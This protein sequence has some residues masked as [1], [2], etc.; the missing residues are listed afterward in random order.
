MHPA[1]GRPAKMPHARAV[2]VADRQDCPEPHAPGDPH[3]QLAT[4]PAVTGRLPARADLPD[5]Y[6]HWRRCHS[7]AIHAYR[8][9]CARFSGRGLITQ[10]DKVRPALVSQSPVPRLGE[11]PPCS[12]RVGPD[13]LAGPGRPAVTTCPAP[14]GLVTACDQAP[15]GQAG[16]AA[17]DPP[18]AG[19]AVGCQERRAHA[20][21]EAARPS[22]GFGLDAPGDG[23]VGFGDADAGVPY[24]DAPE[25]VSAM[26]VLSCVRAAMPDG[27]PA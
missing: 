22:C 17:H 25:P 23:L 20:R 26:I 2:R 6:R 9:Q 24:L 1:S 15:S 10:R 3:Q 12:H 27:Q 19:A 18:R 5:P 14:G 21:D 4:R 7:Q 16:Q 11:V 13:V 8:R